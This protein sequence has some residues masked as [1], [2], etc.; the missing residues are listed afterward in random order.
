M[1]THRSHGPHNRR[2]CSASGCQGEGKEDEKDHLDAKAEELCISP[3]TKIVAQN[4]LRLLLAV[5]TDGGE[6]L[7]DVV[8]VWS[9][10]MLLCPLDSWQ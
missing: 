7:W 4:A 5:I 10:Q 9:K 6:A 8:L 2:R 1:K 3:K